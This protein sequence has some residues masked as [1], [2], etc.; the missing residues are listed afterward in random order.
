MVQLQT[1]T[2]LHRFPNTQ[3]V[4]FPHI[5]GM[6]LDF[7]PQRITY[8]FLVVMTPRMLIILETKLVPLFGILTITFGT[9]GK[10]RVT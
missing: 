5:L 4:Q 8:L 3:R 1:Y 6:I 2:A 10:L 9:Y 7:H